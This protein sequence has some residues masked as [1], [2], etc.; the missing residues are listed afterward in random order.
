MSHSQTEKTGWSKIRIDSPVLFYELRKCWG[1]GD[2]RTNDQKVNTAKLTQ[3]Q[4]YLLH[5]LGCNSKNNIKNPQKYGDDK[6]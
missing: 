2:E 5:N 6:R 4:K 1:V 3:K